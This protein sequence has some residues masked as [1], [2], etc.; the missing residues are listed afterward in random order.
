MLSSFDKKLS[1]YTMKTFKNRKIDVRT[2]VAVKEVKKHYMILGD[3]STIPFGLG[4]WSTGIHF[5][6]IF[7][8]DLII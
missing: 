4:V 1:D 7:R 8:L 5:C 6:S 2:G 3:N